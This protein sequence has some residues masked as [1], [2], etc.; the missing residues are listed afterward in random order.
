MFPIVV[1]LGLTGLV[2]AILQANGEFG[3][4]AFVPVLWN[5]VIIV[6][7]GRRDAARARRRP[8]HRLRRSAIVVG[9]RSSCCT[10]CPRCG[11]RGRSRSRWACA[12]R[13]VRRVLVLMLP[14]TLGLGLININLLVDARVRQRW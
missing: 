2:A 9:T 14:V 4:T 5:V 1:L 7:A 3:A 11:A 8:H 12:T 10:C 13:D 6:G